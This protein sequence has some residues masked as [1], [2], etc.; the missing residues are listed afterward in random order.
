VTTADGYGPE[1]VNVAS[2][3]RD[4]GSLLNW[5]ERLLRRRRQCPELGMGHAT[6][7]DAGDAAA[8][9]LQSTWRDSTMV[10][11]HNLGAD[12][13][14]VRLELGDAGSGKRLVDL[15]EHEDLEPEDDGRVELA[16]EAYAYRWWRLEP[17]A[18]YKPSSPP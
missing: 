9:A 16:L 15:L 8:L 10:T 17:A 1:A 6:P 7:I 11:V 14:T 5:F 3:Q 4:D 12:S 2:Q 13:V 18:S